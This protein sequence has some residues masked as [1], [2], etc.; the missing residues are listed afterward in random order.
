VSS[1]A[2]LEAIALDLPVLLVDD[3]GVSPAM[4]NTVF[5]GAG[6]FGSTS[7]LVAGRFRHADAAWLA[8]NYFHDPDA[9]DWVRRLTALVEAREIIELPPLERRYDLWGGALRTA[10][11]RRRMLGEHDRTLPGAVAWGVGVPVRAVVRRV[12]RARRLLRRWVGGAGAADATAAAETGA[13]VPRGDAASVARL[14]EVST[15]AVGPTRPPEMDD[16]VGAGS[17]D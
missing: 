15:R 12:R 13:F 1:T 7:D 2:A 6:L 4:I 5:E 11:E 3:F 17:R 9:A 8:D 10:F 16:A 14:D